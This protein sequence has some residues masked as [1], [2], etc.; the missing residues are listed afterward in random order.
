MKTTI[1]TAKTALMVA[2]L[3]L[4]FNAQ[5]VIS[6]YLVS[7][8]TGRLANQPTKFE[9]KTVQLYLNPLATNWI[10]WSRYD[11]L[12]TYNGKQVIDGVVIPNIG[13][14]DYFTLTITGPNGK[15]SSP[16]KMDMNDKMGTPI[17]TQATI[18]GSASITPDVMRSDI[19][20]NQQV[21][22]ET[23]IANSF[24]STAGAG[25]YT[26]TFDFYN[27]WNIYSG[28][29][30]VYLLVDNC[31]VVPEPATLALAALGLAGIAAL[32]RRNRKSV[33]TA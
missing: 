29:P 8:N 26:L 6:P 14:D 33:A 31:A 17:G 10:A 22:N 25:L 12:V 20:G 5:A 4:S 15:T 2:L 9:T 32:R 16:F 30:N 7:P 18:W 11:H 13:V 3:L 1:R 19:S 27:A 23:G 21:L 24:L 28:H